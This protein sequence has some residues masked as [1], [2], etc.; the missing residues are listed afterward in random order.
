VEGSVEKEK[1]SGDSD[2]NSAAIT[3]VVLVADTDVADFALA[4]GGEKGVICAQCGAGPS[5]YPPAPTL[6]ERTLQRAIEVQHDIAVMECLILAMDT[7]PEK[8][9]PKENDG[10]TRARRSCPAF[11]SRN[12]WRH[13]ARAIVLQ[14]ARWRG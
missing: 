9:P 14:A 13:G 3:D 6:A 10:V 5:T 4:A 1:F 11:C 7:A 2:L 12:H 8:T